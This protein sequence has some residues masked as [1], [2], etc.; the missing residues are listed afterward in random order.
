MLQWKATFNDGTSIQSDDLIYHQIKGSFGSLLT[1]SV[2]TS[3]GVYFELNWKTG[4]FRV[5]GGPSFY[6][7]HI[8][9]LTDIR[10]I[11]FSREVVEFKT[12]QD[13]DEVGKVLA[14]GLGFQGND[15]DGKNQ[16]CYLLISPDSTY[17]I[18]IN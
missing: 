6:I 7:L 10:P 11:C 1:L 14:F 2:E 16:K 18:E 4:Q 5:G 15:T 8:D 12:L 13:S 17:T 9:K 3:E